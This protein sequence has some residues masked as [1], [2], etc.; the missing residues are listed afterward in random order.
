MT[1][2][3]FSHTFTVVP[4]DMD[5]FG[6]VNNVAYVRW[7]QEAAS[8]HWEALA[9]AQEREIYGWILVRHEL[10]YKKQAF[11]NDEITASQNDGTPL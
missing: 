6:H 8:A 3:K 4:E 1:A 9:T 5:L 2:T 10:D 7:V 11:E